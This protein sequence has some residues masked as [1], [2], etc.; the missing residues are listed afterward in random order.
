MKSPQALLQTSQSTELT[1]RHYSSSVQYVRSG[2]RPEQDAASHILDHNPKPILKCDTANT[3]S[4][5]DELEA[6]QKSILKP[7]ALLGHAASLSLS[8]RFECSNR[9]KSCK[10]G[11]RLHIPSASGNLAAVRSVGGETD[12]PTFLNRLCTRSTTLSGIR[13]VVYPRLNLVSVLSH[14]NTPGSLW[15]IRRMVR[16]L[17]PHTFASSRTQ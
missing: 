11:R 3:I 9:V 13:N 1:E 8:R 6:L 10:I 12:H 4:A 2:S 15:K 5:V 7:N 14:L 17:N 16:S